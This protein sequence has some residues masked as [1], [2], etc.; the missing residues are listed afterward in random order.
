MKRCPKCNKVYDDSWAVCLNCGEPLII[1]IQKDFEKTENKYIEEKGMDFSWYKKPLVWIL[2]ILIGVPIALFFIW[3]Y[4]LILFESTPQTLPLAKRFIAMT[5]VVHPGSLGEAF[6]PLFLLG[7]C[8]G[9]MLGIILILKRVTEKTLLVIC[10]LFFILIFI[11]YLLPPIAVS[12]FARHESEIELIFVDKAKYRYLLEYINDN[13]V[14]YHTFTSM[15]F[16][17][18]VTAEVKDDDKNMEN[19]HARLRK[20]ARK[21]GADAIVLFKDTID[22]RTV[23]EQSYKKPDGRKFNMYVTYSGPPENIKPISEDK[24]EN[25]LISSG[26]FITGEMVLLKET[27]SAVPRLIRS[28]RSPFKYTR[29]GAIRDLA[30]IKDERSIGPLMSIVGKGPQK[31][32]YE[33]LL[34]LDALAKMHHEPIYPI[35]LKM[36]KDDADSSWV[37]GM[38]EQFPDKT[39]TLPVLKVIADSNKQKYIREKAQKAIKNIESRKET[40]GGQT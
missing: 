23:Y 32:S 7:I 37:V 3:Y 14:L 39:E 36:T 30:L 5:D 1:L 35:L 4:F 16:R 34:A 2:R 12:R 20:D 15:L 26:K 31:D 13:R 27:N 25:K 28:L 8:G 24:Y 21:R 33:Y 11:P 17:G 10:I 22:E 18:D 9:I 6:L 29:E 40:I 38:L 19:A